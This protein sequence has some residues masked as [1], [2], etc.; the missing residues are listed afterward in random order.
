MSPHQ[1]QVLNRNLFSESLSG[2]VLS[3]SDMVAFFIF[4]I[5]LCVC[6]TDNVKEAYNSK[7]PTFILWNCAV[8]IVVCSNPVQQPLVLSHLGM[9]FPKEEYLC[10]SHL[11]DNVGSEGLIMNRKSS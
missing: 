10:Y 9:V 5:A 4:I 6:F 2:T 8:Y 3:V 11:C 1:V 7:G